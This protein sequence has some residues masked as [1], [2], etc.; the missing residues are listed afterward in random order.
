MTLTRITPAVQGY[1][2]GRRGEASLVHSL[3]HSSDPLSHPIPGDDSP[4][5]EL[6]FG[7][8]PNGPSV[9]R[10]WGSDPRGGGAPAGDAAPANP[11]DPFGGSPVPY[12]LKVLSVGA[13]L[14]VQAH[15][16]K[17][18][19]E[20]LHRDSPEIYRD[21]N[22][23][24]ELAVA[25]GGPFE[26]MCRFRPPGEI[27]AHLE[28]V[29]ELAAVVRE[30]ATN[31]ASGMV[32]GVTL[33]PMFQN[34]PPK[35]D[36]IDA[37][38]ESVGAGDGGCAEQLRA[39]YTALM[40]APD[41]FVES[42]I[43]SLISRLKQMGPKSLSKAESLA[44][45]LDAQYPGGDVGVLSAF[46]LNVVEVP[47]GGALFMGAG[48]PHAYISGNCVEVMARSD[49]VVRGG[50]T[51]KLKDVPTLVSM[52]TYTTCPASAVIVEGAVTGK[53]DKASEFSY[54]APVEEFSLSRIEVSAGG[55]Y[56]RAHDG[57]GSIIIVLSG[58]GTVEAGGV[59]RGL[60]RGLSAYVTG[61]EDLTFTASEDL[62]IFR[63]TSNS[64]VE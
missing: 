62:V 16:D 8:H 51:V 11:A 49:N 41:E 55:S 32:K 5:A 58:A 45:R 35:P 63:A 6:W 14:S 22:H 57:R 33:P 52:L 17:A 59:S 2:W 31:V 53:G 40:C 30:G 9:G 23:K 25:V 19:A 38:R 26:A 64:P 24:P 36:L 39:V 29:P 18:L 48:E 12:L 37:M 34:V 56:S 54:P 1:A 20:R 47:E 13:A 10:C 44:I 61:D 50:C 28:T 43:A 27:L 46:L 15:P 21:P 60:W 4:G 7:D 42:E 3:L